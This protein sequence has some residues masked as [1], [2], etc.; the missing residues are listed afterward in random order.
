MSRERFDFVFGMGAGCS[1][2]RMLRERG[3]QYASF[4]LDWVGDPCLN[5]AVDIRLVADLAAG[6]FRKWFEK[7]N[8][9]RSALYDSSK[10]MSFYD[11]EVKLFFAHDFGHGCDFEREYKV[12]KKKYERRIER[13]MALLSR[14]KKALVVW[15]A[16]PR[17]SGE[18]TASDMQYVLSAFRR[19]Y[20]KTEFRVF[21]ANCVPG[22][23][24]AKMRIE[25]GD[26]WEIYSFDYRVV[27]VGKPTWDVRTELFSPLLDR[28]EAVDYRTWAEK[29]ANAKRE[30]AREFEKFKA[31]SPLDLILTKMRF[32]L[33]RHL[34]RMLERKGVLLQQDG[35]HA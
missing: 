3:L 35:G 20:P 18:A 32:K 8:L 19:F 5:A 30:R 10:H 33:Y 23:E 17:G 4:P 1:C 13:F 12:A 31:T 11:R 14:A 27:T 22:I 9:E 21:A 28:Y 34:R 29:R 26:G 2:S 25:R 15:I 16:D 24:P 6:G 7:E